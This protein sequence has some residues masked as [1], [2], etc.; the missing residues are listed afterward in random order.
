MRYTLTLAAAILALAFI[1]AS[2]GRAADEKANDIA[3]GYV[4]SID[5]KGGSFVLGGKNESQWTF[6]FGV[7]VGEREA[8][9]LLDGKRASLESAIKPGRK[10]SVSSIT[11]GKELWA[12]KV[13]V[14]SGEK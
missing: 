8:T 5:L 3:N 13:E 11:V 7:N 12:T 1:N 10:A 4:H 14:T 2:S 6:R 9:V